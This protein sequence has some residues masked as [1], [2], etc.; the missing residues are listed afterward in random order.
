[1][2]TDCKKIISTGK[3]M[4]RAFAKRIIIRFIFELPDGS[5]G[6]VL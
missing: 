5:M 4:E 2:G 3:S 6:E 1:M